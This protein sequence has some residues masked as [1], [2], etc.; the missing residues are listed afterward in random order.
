M[1]L[2]QFVESIKYY[3]IFMKV[4]KGQIG[5]QGYRIGF[6]YWNAGYEEKAKHYLNQNINYLNRANELSSSLSSLY[7]TIYVMN[8]NSTRL[9]GMWKPNMW[10]RVKG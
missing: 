4:R 6:V 2:G 3:E 5:S 8:P 10:Q 9:S 7:S 1:D